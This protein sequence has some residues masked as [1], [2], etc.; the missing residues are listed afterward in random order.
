MKHL[1]I[2]LAT[3]AGAAALA[4]SATATPP[5]QGLYGEHLSHC[6]GAFSYGTAENPL[7]VTLVPG[8]GNSF[9]VVGH[10][11]VIQSAEITDRSTGETTSYTFGVKAGQVKGQMVTCEGDFPDYHVVSH[12]VLIP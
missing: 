5:G 4:V 10:H 6:F 9:W 7:P 11:L 3:C 12:D 8:A 1:A 2:A